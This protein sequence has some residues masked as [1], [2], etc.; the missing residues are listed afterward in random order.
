MAPSPTS[1]FAREILKSN[2]AYAKKAPAA[3]LEIGRSPA[4]KIAIL[5]CM[6][7]RLEPLRIMGL[8]LGDAHV[9][10]TAGGRVRPSTIAQLII[11]GEVLGTRNWIVMHHTDCSAAAVT[12]FELDALANERRLPSIAPKL[13]TSD[14]VAMGAGVVKD[15]SM[16]RAHSGVM[17]EISIHGFVYDVR[18]AKL[19]EIAEASLLGRP[20]S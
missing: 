9:L 3:Q 16:L 5:T 18:A 2:L 7:A 17:D 10:R 6:D 12:D 15:V 11:S 8:R 13:D 1:E 19:H 14:P 4:R 20:R